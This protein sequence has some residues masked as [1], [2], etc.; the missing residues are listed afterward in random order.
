MN[1]Y[2]ERTGEPYRIQGGRMQSMAIRDMFDKGEC[3]FQF[4]SCASNK[5]ER[6]CL[7]T[8][9]AKAYQ[10]EVGVEAADHLRA[11]PRELQR[12]TERGSEVQSTSTIQ[13]VWIT[14]CASVRQAKWRRRRETVGEPMLAEDPP[15]SAGGWTQVVC[16][17]TR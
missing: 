12:M 1:K 3:R 16:Y 14:D 9:A 11:C 6:V 2:C 7:L 4:L 15:T 13:A 17:L 8:L 10:V 5:L